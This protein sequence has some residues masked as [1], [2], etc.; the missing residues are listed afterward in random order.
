MYPTGVI[1]PDETF[2]P[3]KPI[4]S[5]ELSQP[6]QN[7]VDPTA[8]QNQA[9]LDEIAQIQ[10]MAA[11][12]E[13]PA[14]PAMSE[15]GPGLQVTGN[16]PPAFQQA[17]GEQRRQ[18]SP[19][20][21]PPSSEEPEI[22][23]SSSDRYQELLQ[24]IR[25]TK[26]VHEEITLPSKG[27]FYN[28]EDGPVDGKLHIRPMTGKEEEI[29]ATPRFV[30]GGKAMNMIF[31]KCI[32]ENYNS[33]QFLTQDRTY[34]L[35][36]LRGISYTPE[37]DVEVKCP[38]CDKKFATVLNLN[39]M[40]VDNCPEDF[41]EESLKGILP[42]T[43]V[44]FAYRLSKGED[45]QR[46]QDYRDRRL[47]DF[48]SSGQTDDTLLYRTALL[49]H[50]LGGCTDKAAIRNLLKELP[51]SDVAYLRNTVTD[52]PFGVDTGVDIYCPSC[53]QEFTVDLP[54]EA[55]FFFPRGRKKPTE[56]SQNQGQ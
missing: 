55:N 19:A 18:T 50:H 42:S 44:D 14:G 45:E 31:N 46:I 53:L 11:G 20:Q 47:K 36:Y 30:K 35:I 41:K 17:L 5:S 23:S 13:T 48:D 22:E 40:Y 9:K 21:R 26:H 8:A 12:E 7:D 33:E 24:H 49:L 10:R 28:G 34:L 56:L 51:I 52:P 4:D 54:L 37:Y 27:K 43:Q 29:L 16:M 1:M 32:Q 3:R 15:G 25:Q 39:D 2:R 6:V 38:E